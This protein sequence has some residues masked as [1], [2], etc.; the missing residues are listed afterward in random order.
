MK[1]L[2]TILIC[3]NFT[4]LVTAQ[5]K[6]EIPVMSG[7][8][9]IQQVDRKG[10]QVLIE[11]DEKFVSKTWAHKLKEFGKVETDKGSFIIHGAS[12]PGISTSCTVYSNVAATSKGVFVFWAIDLGSEYVIEGHSKYDDAKKK[13]RDYAAAIYIADVN[14]QIAAAE[15]ALASSVKNQE[16]LVKLGETLKSNTQKNAKEKIDLQTK[17]DD[18]ARELK[19]LQSEEA[20]IENRLKEVNATENHEEQQKLLK[21]SMS[22][23]NN[24]EKNKEQK[25]SLTNKLK[26][27]ET[28]RLQLIEATKTNA[29]NVTAA[30]EDVAKMTKAVEIVKEKLA[31]YQ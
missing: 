19:G 3:L 23:T 25:I 22:T 10:M 5:T 4:F 9:V 24:V 26:D 16:R 31:L 11:L 18:N 21:E 27:N 12:I 30:N 20:R 29:A 2:I 6:K 7:H 17:L 1:L 28:E 8:S 15:A 13:L 14:V